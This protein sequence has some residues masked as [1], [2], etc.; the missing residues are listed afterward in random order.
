MTY[1]FLFLSGIDIKKTHLHLTDKGHGLLKKVILDN[2]FNLK[3]K[4]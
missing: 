2:L 3:S 4:M 1:F